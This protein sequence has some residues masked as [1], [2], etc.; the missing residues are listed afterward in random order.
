ML[1]L[2]PPQFFVSVSM[3]RSIYQL[4]AF[5]HYTPCILIGDAMILSDTYAEIGPKKN[6]AHP[7]DQ[8]YKTAKNI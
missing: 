4:N 7:I 1:K 2:N 6:I 8:Q 5:T 3:D